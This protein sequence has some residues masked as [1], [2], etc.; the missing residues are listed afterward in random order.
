MLQVFNVLKHSTANEVKRDII[1]SKKIIVPS[2]LIDGNDNTE[3]FIFR[4]QANN[5]Y[6]IKKI[7]MVYDFTAPPGIIYMSEDFMDELCIVD[8]DI[9]RIKLVKPP[10]KGELI[11]IRPHQEAFTKLEDPK[12]FLERG[13][14]LFHPIINLGE[15]IRIGLYSFD[16]VD[17]VPDDVIFT[18]DT[19]LSVDF[20]ESRET[21]IRAIK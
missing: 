20:L 5:R 17:T 7:A 3:Y 9:V 18:I 19:D 1:L 15:T 6:R 8:G 16:I 10:P 14:N 12:G 4:I 21:I 2:S 13:I 11:R